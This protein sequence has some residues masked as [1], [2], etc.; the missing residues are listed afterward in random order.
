MGVNVVEREGISFSH[1]ARFM[2]VGTMNPEEGD[3]RPQLLDR[4]ALCVDMHGISDPRQRVAIVERRIAYESDPEGFYQEWE[5]REEQ[6]SWEIAE[7][8]NRMPGVHHSQRD[9]YTI[10]QLTTSFR[11]DG[12]RA[13]IV[14]LKTARAHAAWQGR[15]AIAEQDILLAA[16]L[17]L[18]HRL[19]R[20]P[21]EEA[22]MDA[23]QLEDRLKKARAEAP[24]DQQ[25]QS[26]SDQ[27]ESAPSVK[28][29]LSR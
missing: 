26:K 15:N 16:E 24:P 5:P 9:L 21:F 18:P 23:G 4:F 2:L 8:R 12:H 19:K 28:K 6:L 11:V 14:I 25:N 17:A 1:P 29:A 7:A 22:S 3:L 20:Q 13:D 10:A 27:G